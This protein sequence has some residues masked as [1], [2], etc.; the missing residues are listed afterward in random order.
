MSLCWIDDGNTY[1][2]ASGRFHGTTTHIS[3]CRSPYHFG[4]GTALATNYFMLVAMLFMVGLPEVKRRTKRHKDTD[5][6]LCH[7]SSIRLNTHLLN[8]VQ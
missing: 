5:N 3:R 4:F 1:S 2:W 6:F 7:G 8:E